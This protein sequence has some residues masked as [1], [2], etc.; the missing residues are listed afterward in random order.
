MAAAA[1]D[2][3]TQKIHKP[4]PRGVFNNVAA[5]ICGAI[6]V[7]ES[8]TLNKKYPANPPAREG[9][10]ALTVMYKAKGYHTRMDQ[11][12]WFWVM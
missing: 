3:G 8:Y 9:L 10:V 7:K 6:I 5:I 1:G 2:C 11:E 4:Q 12:E